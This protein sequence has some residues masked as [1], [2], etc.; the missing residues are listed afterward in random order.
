MLTFGYVFREMSLPHG[1][2][3]DAQA[4]GGDR[5][6]REPRAWQGYNVHTLSNHC[7]ADCQALSHD[8]SLVNKGVE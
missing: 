5:G 3:Q 2:G 1:A 8:V 7:S 4:G 6:L